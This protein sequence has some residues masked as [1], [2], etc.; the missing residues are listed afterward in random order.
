MAAL[1]KEASLLTWL[2]FGWC[3]N[4]GFGG[5]PVTPSGKS[6]SC[7]QNAYADYTQHWLS[8]CK[9]GMWGPA[10]QRVSL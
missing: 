8:F 7:S 1:L 4:L 2:T 5:A 3:L 10:W 9:S 6:D